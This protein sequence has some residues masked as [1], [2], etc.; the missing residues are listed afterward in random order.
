VSKVNVI[1]RTDDEDSDPDRSIRRMPLPSLKG[2]N[3][4][5]AVHG[6]ERRQL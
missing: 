2:L 3:R 6:V 4:H 5:Q 1:R